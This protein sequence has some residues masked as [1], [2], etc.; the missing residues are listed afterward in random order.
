MDSKV[1]PKYEID[2]SRF[3]SNY[4]LIRSTAEKEEK[5]K[6]NEY[7]NAI[8]FLPFRVSNSDKI[9]TRYAYRKFYQF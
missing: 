8:H 4:E 1:M 7:K 3:H 6:E 2:R 5:K 9:S